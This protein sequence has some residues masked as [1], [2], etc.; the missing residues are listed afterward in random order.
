MFRYF[1]ERRPG[2]TSKCPENQ[3]H[4]SKNYPNLDLDENPKL[5]HQASKTR[6]RN[7]R[8]SEYIT[9]SITRARNKQESEQLN[10]N[11]KK[12]TTKKQLGKRQQTKTHIHESNQTIKEG[13]TQANKQQKQKQA[14]KQPNK[15]DGHQ[16]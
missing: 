10:S 1:V 3:K 11:K 8:T 15:A 9:N 6:A 16:H 2:S 13:K 7:T 12:A 14:I 5:D 4:M